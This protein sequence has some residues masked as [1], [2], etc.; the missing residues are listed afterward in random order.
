MKIN[1]LH[2][3]QREPISG[4]GGI[5]GTIGAIS[6]IAGTAAPI[7]GLAIGAFSAAA[8]AIQAAKQRKEAERIARNTV[9][10]RATVGSQYRDIYSLAESRASQGLT[11]QAL[12]V[13]NDSTNRGL[14][15]SIDALLRGGGGVNSIS[16]LYDTA[17][18]DYSKVALLEE[19]VRQ[20]NTQTYIS[21]GQDLAAEEEKVWQINDWGPYK[22]RVQAIAD[23][24]QQSNDNKWKAINTGLSSVLNFGLASQYK[25]QGDRVFGGPT[26]TTAAPPSAGVPSGAPRTPGAVNSYLQSLGYRGGFKRMPGV[27]GNNNDYIVDPNY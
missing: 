11:D 16:D 8:Q 21:A 26:T 7:A 20:K 15:T 1:F 12:S 13:Y 23:L 14:T 9:R 4:A 2:R 18:D 6:G 24:R 22:D 25:S 10:P 17:Q 19:E 3:L 5:L 27:S